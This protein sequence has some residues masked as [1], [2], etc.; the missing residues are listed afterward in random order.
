MTQKQR[1][2]VVDLLLLGMFADAPLKVSEDQKLVS[3]IEEI[4]W[5]SYQAPDL[6]LQSAIARARDTLETQGATKHRLEKIGEELNE[7][8]LRQRALEYL[9]QFLGVDGAV[10]AEESKFLELVREALK[11][12]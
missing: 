12:A 4:G 8:G 1:E 11:T 5:N 3:V 9:T 2:A 6:Y 7:P 10:D